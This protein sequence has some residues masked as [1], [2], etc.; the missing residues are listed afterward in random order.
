MLPLVSDITDDPRKIPRS[1]ANHAVTRLPVQQ[2]AIRDAMVDVV[3]AGS[4]H[5]AYPVADEQ[6]WRHTHDEMHVILNAANFVEKYTG[7]SGG[8]GLSGIYADAGL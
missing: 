4:F 8:H 6:R 5:L 3:T 7:A 1:K 2:V